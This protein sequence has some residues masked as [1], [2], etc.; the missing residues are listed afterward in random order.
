MPNRAVWAE[1]D[2]AA[3]EHNIREIKKKV[4]G[5]AKFCAVIK[6]NAY[7]H[8][9]IPVA[10]TA[11]AAGADY[12]AVAILNEALELRD[13]GF[14]EPILILGF[15]PLEQSGILV[16]RGITQTVFSYEAA[17]ALSKEAV[18]QEKTAKIHLKIDTGM[19][20]IGILPE[21]AGEFA[22]R[23][24]QLPCIE[25]EG[26]FS[27]F[28]LADSRDKSFA[29][30]QL[31]RFK[32]AIDLIEKQG[33][34]IPLKHIAN[35]AA[36]L[37]MPQAHFD[38][39]RAGIILYGLWP[40]DEVEH[41]VDLRPAMV[42]KAKIAYLKELKKGQSIGY[43]R[44]FITN[45]DSLIATLPIGYADG[46]TRL[47]SGKAQ[48]EIA[49]KRAFLV[50]RICMDQCMIDVTDLENIHNGD[51]VVLFGSETLPMDEAAAWLG[52]INYELACMVSSRV[53]RI[54]R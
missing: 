18:L 9:V 27:H 28:A 24:Q 30:E 34:H 25:L 17:E 50:G 13:A 47:F 36:T 10:R 35:S 8:G 32:Q 43:G 38:M 6:A 54:Y 53:P 42:L 48:V 11:I 7:G 39:V 40:S 23:I 12:L 44:T 31:Q 26:L 16:D 41:C 21:D 20:R 22:K 45:R 2:L 1:V 29:N 14:T 15:T 46:Y 4:H 19:S 37:E 3:I 52:T 49:G 33:I 51:E 5:D